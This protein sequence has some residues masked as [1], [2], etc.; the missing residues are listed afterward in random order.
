MAKPKNRS[1]WIV[2]LTG[3]E[4][5]KFR[6]G[7]KA[8]E[9]LAESGHFDPDKLPKGVSLK[10]LETAFEVQVIRNDK[11]GNVVR[12]SETFDTY[13]EAENYATKQDAELEGILQNQGGFVVGFQTI[14]VEEVLK[15][16]HGEHYKGK[17]S[18]KETASVR[19]QGVAALTKVL[20]LEDA[21]AFLN[22]V[23]DIKDLD[24]VFK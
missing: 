6:F 17:S 4:P 2:K 1:P 12:R 23:R 19:H 8:V 18:F 22:E 11:E 7:S 21:N 3:Q 9:F 16:F 13:A 5:Q 15:K 24:D 14:T 10:Q 20:S